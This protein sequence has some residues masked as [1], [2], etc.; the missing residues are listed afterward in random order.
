MTFH[1]P[2]AMPP[3][4]VRASREGEGAPDMLLAPWLPMERPL[5]GRMWCDVTSPT[6]APFGG[7]VDFPEG[8]GPSQ[9]IEAILR[10]W[11]GRPDPVGAWLDAEHAAGDL[12]LA[13]PTSMTR[14]RN[15]DPVPRAT[16]V[17]IPGS[18]GRMFRVT[19]E[20]G[21]ILLLS[22]EVSRGR[23]RTLVARDGHIACLR[24]EP[25]ADPEWTVVPDLG[26]VGTYWTFAG[27]DGF[28]AMGAVARH[29]A[30]AHAEGD[31]PDDILAV[32][33]HAA[34]RLRHLG[35]AFRERVVG[36]LARTRSE[37]LDVVVLAWCL[38]LDGIGRERLPLR[39]DRMH[40]KFLTGYPTYSATL[41]CVVN[42]MGS[43][44]RG[45]DGSGGP[46]G[47]IAAKASDEMN[48]L[49]NLSLG[50]HATLVLGYDL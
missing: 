10:L 12:A 20:T 17:E 27:H 39:S 41:E 36:I 19:G 25:Y 48:F 26:P 8:C 29:L 7:Y 13:P 35:P 44:L 30:E 34:L 31:V 23:T 46:H 2:A 21:A 28:A 5:E 3:L 38:P 11:Q 15:G 24:R 33:A 6:N 18:S 14:D 40:E 43:T 45:P 42:R 32:L 22:D 37:D 1:D 9:A 49:A 4:L 47:E 50:G 16:L